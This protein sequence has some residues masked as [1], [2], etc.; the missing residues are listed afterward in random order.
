MT[1]EQTDK[2]LR[3]RHG[4]GYDRWAER[5]SKFQHKK[6]GHLS[7]AER[8][9]IFDLVDDL[10]L[11][12]D[13]DFLERIGS[14]AEADEAQTMAIS[15]DPQPFQSPPI[16]A[17]KPQPQKLSPEQEARR[18]EFEDPN[19]ETSRRWLQGDEKLNSER[20]AIYEAMY[21]GQKVEI[22]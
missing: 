10:G 3:E 5:V 22:T 1:R 21:A 9:L 12:N 2:Q 16:E 4:A 14:L 20:M 13:V 19:S 18:K 11:A 8:Q 6:L 7:E 17:A 15:P